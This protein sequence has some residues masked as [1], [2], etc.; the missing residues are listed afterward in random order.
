MLVVAELDECAAT[1]V[2]DGADAHGGP[3]ED[4]P[5]L[6]RVFEGLPQASIREGVARGDHVGR[7][8]GVRA[9]LDEPVLEGHDLEGVERCEHAPVEVVA[10]PEEGF[11]VTASGHRVD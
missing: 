2:D 9:H 7:Q 10:E 1:A 11:A 6:A 8:A 4:P 5:V 3:E